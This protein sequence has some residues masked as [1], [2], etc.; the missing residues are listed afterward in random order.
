MN[1][2]SS[3]EG[4]R[5][6]L[7]TQLGSAL[8]GV[9]Y[10]LDEPTIGL[11]QRDTTRLMEN[12]IQLRDGGNTVVVV[13]H[14]RETMTYADHLIEIGPQAGE[15]GGQ[16]VAQGTLEELSQ[17]PASR[18]GLYLKGE[19]G[20]PLP[21]KRR[22]PG[23]KKL[24][25]TGA[26]GHNLQ[27]LDVTFPL[28]MIT[29]V[30][31]VSGSGK[32]SLVLKTLLPALQQRLQHRKTNPLP[33]KSLQGF[34]S[35]KRVV[36]IDQ[37]AIGTSSR[38]NPGTYLGVFKL[39]REQFAM[40]PEARTRGYHARRFSFNVDGGRCGACR[41][42]GVKRIEMH[43]LPDVFVRCDTCDGTRFN[44]ETLEIR[45][46][47]KTISDVLEMTVQEVE[48]FF[49]AIPA[50]RSRL[51]PML[52]VGLGYLKLGQPANTLSGGE[53]QRLKIARELNR[54]EQGNALYLMDE[55][56]TGLHFQEVE[57][58]VTVL[59][60]LVEHDNS[61][62]VIEHHLELIKC[63]DFIIDIGPEAGE[64]GGQLVAQ[65]TPEDLVLSGQGSYT[66]IYLEPYL[67]D[68]NRKVSTTAG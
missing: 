6:R 53:A 36:H 20:I 65:G 1:S 35:L 58:L 9:I 62:I 26:S 27:E 42:E 30:T 31:G 41:G 63:A 33:H 11:H 68:K 12:L 38:S 25:L 64:K 4:Q 52:D 67:A 37:S 61:V 16:L 54:R 46:R 10:I 56:T 66:A 8:S 22:A 60:Q 57:R 55:P 40:T 7:A 59:N 14:D 45:Y 23:W 2:L 49:R 34:E 51:L 13:E 17:N 48:Q 19:L 3:G 29:C 18:T 44:R 39:I 47:G 5:I 28:G 43:F 15:Q 50:I 24:I 21:E 32:S